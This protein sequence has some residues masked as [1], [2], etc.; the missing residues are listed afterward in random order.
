MEALVAA[1]IELISGV[2]KMI[3]DAQA[4]KSEDHAAILA[5][6]QAAAAA[7]ASAE[8]ASDALAQQGADAL[9]G[10]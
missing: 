2:V 6:L 4:A 10:K 5:R 1:A 8:A 9:A 3:A 7:L